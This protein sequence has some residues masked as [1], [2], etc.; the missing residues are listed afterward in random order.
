MALPLRRKL[1]F[2][3]LSVVVF[4]V[5]LEV[6]LRVT[7]EGL[8][9][10]SIPAE[11]V[12]THV[13]VET[14]QHDPLLG[15][16]RVPDVV[17]GID[18]NGFRTP[19]PFAHD[20]P[21]GTWRA[22]TFGDS[23]TYGAGVE[24]D[25][26]YSAF[27]L[28]ALRE[29]RPD[30]EIELINTGLSGYG[31]LQ[32]LRLIQ[33]KVLAWEPDLLI[34]DCRAFDQPRDSLVYADPR[35]PRLEGLLFHWR[36]WYVLRFAIQRARGDTVPMDARLLERDPSRAERAGNHDHIMRVAAEA[37]VALVFLDYPLLEHAE[38]RRPRGRSALPRPA[39]A[40]P[41]G[42]RG[43][44]GLRSPG[45]LRPAPRR[46]V[47]RQQPPDRRGQP[48]RRRGTGS[49]HRGVRRLGGTGPGGGKL[50][51]FA[52]PHVSK[53]PWIKRSMDVNVG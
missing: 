44:A 12:L 26:S 50:W 37:G 52:R 49:G 33:H 20:K 51:G 27:A 39:A 13:E 22:F 17:I 45:A 2:S 38:R 31:S 36:T 11:T 23:Q 7:T 35:F 28:A 1:A 18:E 8:G 3:A 43:R 4:L 24:V 32:A 16:V 9:R 5:G 15:W 29:R 47:P 48:R 53:T 14:L 19:E 40:A 10:A 42:C 34:V 30:A 41:P 46:P 25:E 6:V 21:D